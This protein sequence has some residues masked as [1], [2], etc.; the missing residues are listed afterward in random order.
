[1]IGIS[2]NKEYICSVDLAKKRDYTT[3]QIYKQSMDFIKHPLETRR[4]DVAVAFLD[5]V[6]QVKMQAVRYTEQSKIIRDLLNRVKLLENTQLLVDG[7]G[8]GEPVIDIMREDGMT[9]IA[10]VFTGGESVNPV[11]AEFDSLFGKKSGSIRGIQVLKEI[12]VPKNDLVHAGVLVMEQG[13]LRLARNLAH[14][15]DFKRQLTAFKGKVNE[16]T[17]RVKYE[18]ENNNIH[19]DFVVTYLM[20]SWWA[21]YSRASKTKDLTVAKEENSSWNPL[22]FV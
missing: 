15:E 10:I 1:M 3:I 14:E 4:P 8:V 22:D 2:K 6:Y 11:Y 5:L 9:P 16:K 17:K 7:T 21:S 20:A 12:C 19:D 18:N 13:R